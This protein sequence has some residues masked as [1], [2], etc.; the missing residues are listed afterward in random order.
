MIFWCSHPPGPNQ[1]RRKRNALAPYSGG[2][3][4]FKCVPPG[5]IQCLMKDSLARMGRFTPMFKVFQCKM[6]LNG[7]RGYIININFHKKT[8]TFDAGFFYVIFR[9]LCCFV[10][11]EKETWICCR[12][13][14][15]NGAWGYNVAKMSV[16]RGK[17]CYF[18][19]DIIQNVV[20]S[21]KWNH[22]DI[23]AMS[24][25]VNSL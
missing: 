1:C 25:H 17:T 10:C 6:T 9:L 3:C 20:P 11:E 19:N 2:Q 7:A 24:K 5:P 8:Q 13:M 22:H 12:N 21:S 4:F 16:S 14:T 15:L 23:I 18:W